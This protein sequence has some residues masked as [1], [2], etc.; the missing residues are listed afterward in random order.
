[1]IQTDGKVV[2][3]IGRAEYLR[4]SRLGAEID[5]CDY[6]VRINWTLPI[7]SGMAS[8]VGTRTD[9]LYTMKTGGW[10]DLHQ[11]ALR[12]QVMPMQVDVALRDQLSEQIAG[13]TAT[14]MPN[15]GT[16]AIVDALNGGAT[17]VRAFG[18]DFHTSMTYADTGKS[19]GQ[20]RILWERQRA[21]GRRR[22]HHPEQDAAFLASLA[23]TDS[24]FRPDPH[25]L[26][27]LGVAA[28]ATN[29]NAAD[30]DDPS[31]PFAAFV[32]LVARWRTEGGLLKRYG[33]ESS[34]HVCRLHANEVESAIRRARAAM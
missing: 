23:K 13:T 24:R 9:L 4:S 3:V 29:G 27:I 31:D 7:A 10:R 19:S 1:M 17:E 6:V 11:R 25:M 28:P 16:V 14:Y 12:E 33:V 34:D 8:H 26:G 2:A 20:K 30:P 18:F 22:T 21:G 15:T 5:G 32:A